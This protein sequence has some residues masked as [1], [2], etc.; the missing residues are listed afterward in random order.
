MSNASVP[1]QH[2]PHLPP[3]RRLLFFDGECNVCNWGVN[4]LIHRDPN[5]LFLFASLQSK[6][7][8]RVRSALGQSG[9]LST[10]VLVRDGHAYIESDAVLRALRD[11]GW[12]WRA[13]SFLRWIPRPLRDALYRGFAK[14]RYRVFGK[15]D[16][17]RI[18][19]ADERARFWEE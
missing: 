7:G 8:Q 5:G 14:I 18:P 4:L 15:R 1:Y 6:A 11:L 10:L 16:S 9:E 13:L 3:G 19:T 17:C 12:P 2:Q